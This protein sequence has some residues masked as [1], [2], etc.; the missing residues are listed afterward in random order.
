MLRFVDLTQGSQTVDLANDFLRFVIGFFEVISTSAP[1]IYHSALLLSPRTS[2]VWKLYGPQASFMTRVIKGLPTSWDLSVANSRYSSDVDAVAW[3]PCSKFIAITLSGFSDVAI[4]DATT[5]E[6]CHTLHS[7]NPDTLWGGLRFS[8][9]GHLLTGC[10][11]IF[12]LDREICIGSWDLQTG[13]IVGYITPS[14]FCNSITYSVCGMMLGG[15]FPES[16]QIII[17]DILSGTQLFSHSVVTNA[18]PLA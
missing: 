9:N 3:S 6:Q 1:H 15:Y 5:L 13:G 7:K 18:T 4:L 2:G 12:Y 17:Y 10:G 8:P 11:N 16:R 14:W